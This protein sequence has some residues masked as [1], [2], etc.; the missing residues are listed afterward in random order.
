ML[1][2]AHFPTSSICLHG[3]KEIRADGK[4]K[5]VY[6]LYF[7]M[8]KYIPHFDFWKIQV[9]GPNLYWCLFSSGLKIPDLLESILKLFPLDSYVA[10]PVSLQFYLILWSDSK[11]PYCNIQILFWTQ[12]DI[13][14]KCV[15]VC[16]IWFAS[17]TYIL[18]HF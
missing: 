18:L 12:Y 17:M 16:A 2:D 4:S 3:P 1:T 11:L 5:W 9:S 7:V 6:H 8:H 14:G 13:R 15:R 10:E